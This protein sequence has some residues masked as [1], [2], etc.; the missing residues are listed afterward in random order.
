MKRMLSLIF[1]LIFVQ[2]VFAQKYTFDVILLNKK[3]GEMSLQKII[4]NEGERYLIKS[5]S[6]AK[7]LFIKESARVSFDVLFKLGS[8]VKSLYTS[9]KN[10][11]NIVTTVEKKGS[12]YNISYNGNN[13]SLDNNISF[14][15]VMLYFKEPK[16]VKEVFVERI[17]EF[18][19]LKNVAVGVYQYLQPDGTTSIYRYT[20]GALTEI[21]LK[22]GIGSVFLKPSN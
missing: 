1:V 8:M 3:I 11:E 9:D 17:G 6:E 5:E 21:E 10:K 20:K 12:N 2:G 19:P 16:G 13:H 7:V 18:L 14:S 22:R 4:N 15:S